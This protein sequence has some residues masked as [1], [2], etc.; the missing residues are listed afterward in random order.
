MT[1]TGAYVQPS[2]PVF[3]TQEDSNA[4]YLNYFKEYIQNGVPKVEGY[5][6]LVYE[7]VYPNITMQ[8]SSNTDGTK[9]YFIC[10]PPA[11]GSPG[12][13]PSEIEL[14]FNGANSVSVTGSGGLNVNTNFGT[15][16]FAPG[17]A[18]TDSA[19]IIKPKSWQAYFVAVNSNTVRFN[20]GSYNTAEPLVIRVDRGHPAPGS[21][22][23]QQNMIWNTYYG[24]TDANNTGAFRGV[25]HDNSGNVYTVGWTTAQLFP[26][27][28]NITGLQKNNNGDTDAVIVKF[29][30]SND[31][32]LWA[33]YYGGRGDDIGNGIAVQPS[34]GNVFITGYTN[35][36]DLPIARNGGEFSQTQLN[37]TGSGT[38]TDMFVAVINGN[39]FDMYWGTYYGGP[40]NESGHAI[41]LDNIDDLYVVGDG[42]PNTPRD[43][44]PGAYNDST[45]NALI[46]EF[47][48]STLDTEWA[49][50][51]GN[52]ISNSGFNSC[53]TDIYNNLFVAGASYGGYP[54]VGGFSFA[55][56]FDDATLTKFSV[57]GTM[58]WSTYF[59]GDAKDV[60]NAVGVDGLGNI[61]MAGHTYSPNT[62]SPL[63]EIQTQQKNSWGYYQQDNGSGFWSGKNGNG[64]ISEFD[65]SGNL[66]WG[67]YFGG[68]GD[69]DIASL[70]IDAG[71]DV[72]V[73]G[74][75]FTND[76]SMVWPPGGEAAGTYDRSSIVLYSKSAAYI[77]AFNSGGGY[78]WGTYG[79]SSAFQ[80]AG[81]GI[82]AYNTWKLYT[83]GITGAFD[84]YPLVSPPTGGWFQNTIGS[85]T[86]TGFI[87][88]FNLIGIPTGEENLKVE[89]GELKVYPNPT[90]DKVTV[91]MDIQQQG[92]VKFILYDLL[93]ESVYTNI[94]N[95]PA[96][97]LNKQIP[98]AGLPNGNYILQV[99]EGNSV[100]HSKITKLQ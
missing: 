71:N 66:E 28:I 20:T 13:N 14:Q 39:G 95:E 9:L 97:T 58:D 37:G 33:G 79:A 72:F 73:T 46:V 45:G 68:K 26:L 35:S 25:T 81:Y 40:G 38:N 76:S 19:G 92:N 24:G 86:N 56:G 53:A 17:T 1:L 30:G 91:Q 64:F 69:L 65:E 2:Q 51:V 100:Y 85:A 94:T 98:L 47:H 55:G 62:N 80:S 54:V 93:G 16:N 31:S 52:A 88:E 67:T 12:G 60:A 96:G 63:Y 99:T 10:A 36:P 74:S 6:R 44:E 21:Y 49:T 50:V 48:V 3:K 70:A 43:H 84:Y 78:Y 87:S 34:G 77:A 23:I 75:V 18:Y 8:V 15:L 32:M 27:N 83:V 29:Q 41:T 61:Y 89:S 57:F 5:S 22:P 82:T 7:N 11:G 42:D 59:G 4:G 90:N